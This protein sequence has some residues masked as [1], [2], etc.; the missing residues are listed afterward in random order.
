MATPHVSGVAAMMLQKDPTLTQPQVED[1]LK[2]TA[3]PLPTAIPGWPFAYNWVRWPGGDV[4]AFLWAA[5][6]TGA[7][8]IQADAALA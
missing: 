6:A 2:G 1:S 5:D 4:Y 7:G 3:T 8:I